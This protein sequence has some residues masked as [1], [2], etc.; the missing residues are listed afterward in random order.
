MFYY[1]VYLWTDFSLLVVSEGSDQQPISQLPI[2][3]NMVEHKQNHTG[4][5]AGWFNQTNS[6][7]SRRTLQ[8]PN[9]AQ[10]RN[11]T[12]I[13]NKIKFSSYIRKFRVEQLQSHV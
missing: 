6:G 7:S 5:A 12:L 8:S 10:R 11:R 3:W 2:P 4:M 1:N 9:P 13:K